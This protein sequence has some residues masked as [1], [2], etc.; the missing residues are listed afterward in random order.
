MP[1]LSAAFAKDYTHGFAPV[2]N[3]IKIYIVYTSD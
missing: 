3:I 2:V 1:L